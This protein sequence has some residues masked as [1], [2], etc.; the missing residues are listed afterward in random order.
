MSRIDDLLSRKPESLLFHYTDTNGLLG[1]LRSRTIWCSSAFHMNDRA[2]YRYGL[3]LIERR[4]HDHLRYV[5]GMNNEAYGYA[6]DD[7]E[8]LRTGMQAFIASFSTEGDLLSQ[9]LAYP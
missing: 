1:I 4:L 7:I 3:D 8:F 2:E 5:R 6:L 9:W